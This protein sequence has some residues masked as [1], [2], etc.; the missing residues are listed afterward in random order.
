MA[1][2]PTSARPEPNTRGRAVARRATG[3]AARAFSQQVPGIARRTRTALGW[4]QQTLAEK[5]GVSQS[6]VSRLESGDLD[7]VSIHELTATLDALD[8]R[9]TLTLDGPFITR[10]RFVKD[11]AHARCI[12]YIAAR[13]ERAGWETRLEVEVQG[14]RSHG[15]I[16]ILAHNRAAAAIVV[17]EVKTIL[18]DV[19][20]AQRQLGWYEREAWAVGRA[21]GW[22]FHRVGAALLLLATEDVERRL[23]EHAALLQRA[24]PVRGT[25]L[26]EWLNAPGEHLPGSGLAL[27]D[28]RSRRRNWLLSTQ[29]DGRRTALP[30][31]DY[32]D[33]M[34]RVR[35]PRRIDS[36]AKVSASRQ[37]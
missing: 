2:G 24:F 20:G 9:V 23:T 32:A 1:R 36:P 17:V 13:L 4:T 18:D 16:D 21:A 25:R 3:E 19:G 29:A 31:R 35:T 26:G 11:A 37:G 6:Q 12:A 15:W 28:P 34:L 5:A 22:R 27:L 14:R 33:F 30:Y 7:A 10:P 8:V